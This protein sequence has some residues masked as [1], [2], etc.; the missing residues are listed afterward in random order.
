MLRN[1]VQTG[2]FW[3]VLKCRRLCGDVLGNCGAC[4]AIAKLAAAL[5]IEKQP[6]YVRR[7]GPELLLRP[8]WF[9]L[10]SLRKNNDA[11]DG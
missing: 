5:S 7:I 11:I 4:C 9:S 2:I 8:S 6:S 1:V 3:E 10:G